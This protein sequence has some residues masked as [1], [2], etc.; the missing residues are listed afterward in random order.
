MIPLTATAQALFILPEFRRLAHYGERSPD[1][2]LP[3]YWNFRTI[4]ISKHLRIHIPE[5]SLTFFQPGDSVPIKIIC[6]NQFKGISSI[7]LKLRGTSDVKPL[8]GLPSVSIS[9][10]LKCSA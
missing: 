2:V 5:D 9:K 7:S 10:K 4:Q 1:E 3:G 6:S 8:D